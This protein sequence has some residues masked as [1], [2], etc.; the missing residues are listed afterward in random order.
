MRLPSWLWLLLVGW[1]ATAVAH[2]AWRL[3]SVIGFSGVS[4]LIHGG[5]AVARACLLLVVGVMVGRLVR[6]LFR[7]S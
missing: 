3:F 6:R 7:R 2:H 4:M 5:H 1:L